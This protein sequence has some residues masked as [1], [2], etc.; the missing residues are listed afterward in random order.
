MHRTEQ[1]KRRTQTMWSAAIF[2]ATLMLILGLAGSAQ[3][4]WTT[5]THINNTNTGNVGIGTT[6][7]NDKLTVYG[8]NVKSIFGES[9]THTNIYST[10]NSQSW[11]ALEIFSNGSS[12]SGLVFSNNLTSGGIGGVTFVNKAAG[13][14]GVNDLRLGGFFSYTDGA[15]NSG[16]LNFWTA[17]GGALGERMRIT[18]TGNIGIGTSSPDQKLHVAG[19][20]AVLKLQNTLSSGHSWWLFSGAFGAP[21]AFGV[22]D[23]SAA[24][25]RMFFDGSGNVGFGTVNPQNPLH[26]ST[27]ASGLRRDLLRLSNTGTGNNT[28]PAIAFGYLNGSTAS[29]AFITAPMVSGQ[30]GAMLQFATGGGGTNFN[31]D[32]SVQMTI[33]GNG[34]VGIGTMAPTYKLDVSG[35]QINASGGLCIAGDC[36]TTWSQVG[37]SSQWAT[38]GASISYTGGNVGIGTSTPNSAY[39]LDI[40]GDVNISGNINAKYQDVAEWVPSTHA[41]AAGTVVVLNPQQSNQV[42]A[43]SEAYDTRVAGVIS[44]RPGLSLGES[45]KD[46][47][48]V[49]TTGRVKVKVDATRAPIRIGDLLVTS[50][51]EGVAMRSEPLVIQGRQIH[52]PG[53]LIGKALEPLEKG[54]GEILVLLSLQ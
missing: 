28:A 37:G 20:N 25:Y 39:K 4:Q 13:V 24:S 8:S 12:Y 45:G 41:F 50:D 42:T 52:S 32:G 6:T 48:L 22:Y 19:D 14:E 46:K 18:K 15:A 35:G 23:E 9:N 31:A 11:N 34:K 2:A 26:V 16:Y 51:K 54:T 40:V 53:T 3:A 43:S 29:P 30:N 5:G 49:A 17:N 7:P 27:A 47:V 10:Y 1:S 33:D 38:S 21:G 36:K 44:E